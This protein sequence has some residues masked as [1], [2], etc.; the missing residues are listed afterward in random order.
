[1]GAAIDLPRPLLLNG[2]VTPRVSDHSRAR[3]IHCALRM[4]KGVYKEAPLPSIIQAL[5]RVDHPA[6]PRRE[7]P[8]GT[9]PW[10]CADS[11]ACPVPDRGS[12]PRKKGVDIADGFKVRGLAVGY[13]LRHDGQEIDGFKARR[14]TRLSVNSSLAGRTDPNHLR[15]LHPWPSLTFS[16]PS[17]AA[18]SSKLLPTVQPMFLVTLQPYHLASTKEPLYTASCQQETEIRR[19]YGRDIILSMLIGHFSASNNLDGPSAFTERS[20]NDVTIA[21]LGKDSVSRRGDSV[22][23][24]D[25]N[26]PAHVQAHSAIATQEHSAIISE[27]SH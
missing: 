16:Q 23:D 10:T 7:D 2:H 4:C 9:V 24:R 26:R 5:A 8:S 25:H 27:E 21:T 3:S 18:Q 6:S 17:N 15:D 13:K 12:H 22:R 14:T 20:C 1:M 11:A 19:S